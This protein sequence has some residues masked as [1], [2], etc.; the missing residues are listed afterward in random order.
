LPGARHIHVADRAG[1]T[2]T[3]RAIECAADRVSYTSKGVADVAE[4]ALARVLPRRRARAAHVGAVAATSATS[5]TTTG[6]AFGDTSWPTMCATPGRTVTGRTADTHAG[7]WVAAAAVAAATAA[8]VAAAT[9]VTAL[10]GAVTRTGTR[11]GPGAAVAGR[12]ADAA[13]AAEAMVAA[14]VAAVTV[15]AATSATHGQVSFR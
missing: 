9:H 8:A 3:R 5:D 12:C 7:S 13:G 14:A 4:S 10:A 2:S 6:A 1:D 15:A 11:A